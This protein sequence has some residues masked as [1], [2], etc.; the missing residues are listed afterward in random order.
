MF[1]K[2]DG[3]E[4]RRFFNGKL[5]T[6]SR[7]VDDEI[8]LIRRRGHELKLEQETWKNIRY[9]YNK[10]DNI[11]EEELGSFTQ[12]PIRLAGHHYS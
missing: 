8:F 2:N 12:Y 7:I 1:I 10:K 4:N 5:A 3:G 6:V 9:N 11:E